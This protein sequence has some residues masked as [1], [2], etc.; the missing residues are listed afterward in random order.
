MLAI[1]FLDHIRFCS[2]YWVGLGVVQMV[3]YFNISQS[4]RVIALLNR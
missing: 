3:Y 1:A 2:Y 4:I